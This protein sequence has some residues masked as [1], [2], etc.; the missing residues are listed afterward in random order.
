MSRSHG[1]I[2]LFN[3]AAKLLAR[4]ET[5]SVSFWTINYNYSQNEF[6]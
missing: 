1:R 5:L 2:F 6:I 4:P 3:I